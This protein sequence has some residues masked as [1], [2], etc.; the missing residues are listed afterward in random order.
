MLMPVCTLLRP[1]Y[2][3]FTRAIVLRPQVFVPLPMVP[4]STFYLVRLSV[5]CC[6]LEH[7]AL[8]THGHEAVRLFPLPITHEPILYYY[9]SQFPY[10]SHSRYFHLILQLSSYFQ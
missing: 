8:H 1:G 4:L 5:T 7:E 3:Y 6:T 9:P 2:L 10:V